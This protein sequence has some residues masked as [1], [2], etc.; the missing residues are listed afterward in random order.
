MRQGIG[1]L[2]SGFE[3]LLPVGAGGLEG[4]EVADLLVN[5]PLIV[6]HHLLLLDHLVED[7]SDRFDIPRHLRHLLHEVTTGHIGR[8]FAWW[9]GSIRPSVRRHDAADI[10]PPTCCMSAADRSH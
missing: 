9:A 6:H 4:D 2:S 3:D 5:E 1:D 10:T 7:P 8:R